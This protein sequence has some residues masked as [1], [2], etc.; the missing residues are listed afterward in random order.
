MVL[1]QV[2]PLEVVVSLDRASTYIQMPLLVGMGGHPCRPIT[3]NAG[4][5]Y[6]DITAHDPP[7]SMFEVHQFLAH[8]SSPASAAV[9]S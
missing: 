4:P 7:T 8:M 2:Q 6:D 5:P 3:A 1:R 9:R